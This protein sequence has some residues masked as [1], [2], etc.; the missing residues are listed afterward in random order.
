VSDIEQNQTFYEFIK[1]L[2]LKSERHFIW[3]RSPFNRGILSFYFIGVICV[4]CGL[5]KA[6]PLGL[7]FNMSI[8]LIVNFVVFVAKRFYYRHTPRDLRRIIN[9]SGS[10]PI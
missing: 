6:R 9:I 1:N 10:S 8:T 5:E 3:A 4:I 2:I 7:A